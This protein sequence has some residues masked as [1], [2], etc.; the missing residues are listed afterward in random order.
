MAL[1]Q[2]GYKSEVLQMEHAFNVILPQVGL[3]DEVAKRQVRERGFKTLYLLHG[4]S[5]DHSIWLRNTSIERYARQYG[6]AVVMPN[7][8]RSF[9]ANTRYGFNYYTY[10]TEELP[11]IVRSYFPLSDR[12]E[13]NAIA[14]LSMGGYGAFMIALRNPGA[15]SAAASLSGAL[16]L[17][18]V[19][20]PEDESKRQLFM[21][22]FGNKEEFT[23]S[24][25]NLYNVVEKQVKAGVKLPRLFQCCGTEDFLYPANLKFKEA[26]LRYGLDLTYEEGPGAHGWSYWDTN[27]QRVLAWMF[28]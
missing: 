27:I 5:D 13:D 24:D 9:Y 28:K 17:D 1:L 26:A 23:S 3:Q 14:G 6:I 22:N 16:D 18:L 20:D 25:Y 15:F 4:L 7:V 19:Y 10:I 8:H 12:R 11:H 21:Q 2:V